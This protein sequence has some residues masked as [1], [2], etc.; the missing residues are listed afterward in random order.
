MNNSS[1]ASPEKIVKHMMKNDAFSQW[2]GIELIELTEG[3]CILQCNLSEK[4]LNGYNIAHGGVIF[5]LADSAVAFT[6]ASYGR[7]SVTIDH[8]ISFIKQAVAGDVLTVK[9]ETISMG[10][11]TGVIQVEIINQHDEFVAVVKSTVYR[12]SE[13]FDL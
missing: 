10:F 1:K 6:S 13:E 11:K 9:A 2:L 8:S 4:M 12:K 7:L 3:R 5:S